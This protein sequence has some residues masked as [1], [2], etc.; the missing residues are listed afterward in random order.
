[1]N[2]TVCLL[3]GW[4]QVVVVTASLETEHAAHWGSQ[5]P[6]VGCGARMGGAASLRASSKM[7]AAWLDFYRDKTHQVPHARA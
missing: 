4:A 1:M 7:R 3:V 2:L 6:V 5:K